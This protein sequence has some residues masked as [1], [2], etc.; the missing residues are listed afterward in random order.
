MYLLG[1][2]GLGYL[3]GST[4][5]KIFKMKYNIPFVLFCSLLPD[6]DIFFKDF[7][8]HR[9][10]THSIV[11]FLILFVPI[12]FVYPRSLPYFASYASHLLVGDFFQYAPLQSLWPISEAWIITPSSLRLYGTSEFLVEISLFIV[13]LILLYLRYKLN[14]KE[15][16]VRFMTF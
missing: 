14:P 5:E 11:V 12:Y 15:F 8:I 6:L 7:L 13:M 9:G 10:P 16:F 3:F 2:L 4:V 1:H